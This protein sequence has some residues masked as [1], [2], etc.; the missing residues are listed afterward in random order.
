MPLTITDEEFNQALQV[1]EGGLSA[2]AAELGELAGV[3][4]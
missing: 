4:R 1:L 2:V 3:S